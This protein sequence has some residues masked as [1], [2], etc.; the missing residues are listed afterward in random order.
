MSNERVEPE[1]LTPA[2]LDDHLARGWYRIGH[3][4]ITTDLLLWGGELRS[5]LWTRLDVRGYRFPR[6]LRKLMARNDRRFQ[7]RTGEL[8]IDAEREQLYARY[9]EKVGGD[10]VESLADV[11]GGDRGRALFDTR[12]VSVWS[13]GLLVAFSWY[14]LGHLSVQSLIGV[15]DPA[16]SKHSLGLYTM[17]L[18]IRE[19]A[20]QGRHFHYAGYVLA[21]PSS[22]DYKLQVGGLQFFDPR[23]SRWLLAPPFARTE[24]PAEIMRSRLDAAGGALRQAGVDAVRYLNPS[25]QIRGL[26][27]Q[28]PLCPTQPLLLACGA[29]A[30]SRVLVAWEHDRGVYALAR[31]RPVVATLARQGVAPVNI[32]LFFVEAKLGDC[33]SAEEVADATRAALASGP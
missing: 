20:A 31:A 19:T 18:E 9:L 30:P 33:G 10:R 21:E 8:V 15:Y 28:A 3:G 6:S 24:S 14:D 12:E 5:T 2:E 1:T 7:V 32:L 29:P 25:L 4:M 26:L 13:E 17:L 22:M 11:V 27:E 23:T 16:F